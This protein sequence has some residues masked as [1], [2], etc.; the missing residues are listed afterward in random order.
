M[1]STL[2]EGLRATRAGSKTAA[3]LYRVFDA[4][5]PAGPSG[6][7]C[8]DG[9]D[10]VQLGRA[11]QR[12]SLRTDEGGKRTLK[13]GIPDRWMSGQHARLSRVLRTWVLEDTKS[14]NGLRRNGE[15]TARAELQDGDVLELGRTFFVVR[16][17]EPIA[18]D[19]ESD[20][21]SPPATGLSTMSPSL[22]ARFS[23][24]LTLARS[25]VSIA[26]GGP[27]GS[28]KEVL[29]RAIH[30]L[31]GRTGPFVAI[32]CGALP[33]ELVESE[34]FG[35]KKGAFSGALEDRPGLIRAAH[36]GRCS[37]TR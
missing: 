28:G 13:L 21:A 24:L 19:L 36:G 22:V 10:E 20:A 4:D 29:A 17:A 7:F 9:V 8:L 33:D 14:K 27:S 25:N 6:R 5:R 37:S 1:P 34:L 31:S 32:N 2:T 26:L 12:V 23:E 35:H 15:P 30:A 11:D 3:V 16:L 18:P